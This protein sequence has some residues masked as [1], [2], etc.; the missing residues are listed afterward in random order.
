[1]CEVQDEV[2]THFSSFVQDILCK[3]MFNAVVCLSNI[4]L[5]TLLFGDVNLNLKLNTIQYNH[6]QDRLS[7]PI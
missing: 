5:R 6:I 2:A 7:T 4:N 1:M 3:D